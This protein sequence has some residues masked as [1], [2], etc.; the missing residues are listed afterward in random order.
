MQKGNRKRNENG[1]RDR[2]TEKNKKIS[3][4]IINIQGLTKQKYMEMESL[5]ND[6]FDINIV[7]LT[8]TQQKIDKINISDG[9]IKKESMRDFKDKKGGGLMVIYKDDKDIEMEKVNSKNLDILDVKGNILKKKVRLIV[10]YMDCGGDREGKERNIEIRAELEKKIEE[11]EEDQALII[12]GDFNGHLGFLG[13]QEENENGKKILEIIN[14]KNL[15]LLNVDEKCKGAYTWERGDQ[16]SAIDLVLVNK[17][18]Y[19]YFDEMNIDE[20]KDEV[21]ISDHNLTEVEV[22]VKATIENYKKGFWKESMYY[23]TDEESLREYR[24]ELKNNLES[25]EITRMDEFDKVVEEAA[26]RKLQA[27]YRRR[28]TGE[29]KAKIEPDWITNEIREEI[30]KRKKLNREKRC[31]TGAERERAFLLY[32]Q[33]KERTQLTEDKVKKILRKLKN[34]KA[35]GPDELKPE[36]YKTIANDSK[37]LEIITKC[38]QNETKEKNKPEKW[39][40]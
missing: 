28:T 40:K 6:S 33:Q 26:K 18:M 35:A 22:S 32:K 3:F 29:E 30:K 13:Y 1:S 12:M 8:E 39:K 2:P 17:E 20:E 14:N 38:L 25:R 15:I 21:D 27:K 23:K 9:T 37:C 4:K 11:V 10:V 24:E 5:L 19:E 7:V 16:R 36:L 34:K 31:L